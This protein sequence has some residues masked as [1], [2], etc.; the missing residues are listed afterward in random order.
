MSLNARGSLNHRLLSQLPFPGAASYLPWV[1]NYILHHH[2]RVW[3]PKEETS[4]GLGGVQAP[5]PAE[6]RK[7]FLGRELHRI[8]VPAPTQKKAQELWTR[9]ALLNLPSSKEFFPRAQRAANLSHPSPPP[10]PGTQVA[11]GSQD[12]GVW[13]RQVP[14]SAPSL[15]FL[16]FQQAVTPDLLNG[17]RPAQ[18]LA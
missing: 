1:L 18:N 6:Y 10:A 9:K 2:P 14:L 3:G 12:R 5:C 8:P 15:G 11:A 4:E 13:G 16:L 7:P 17:K